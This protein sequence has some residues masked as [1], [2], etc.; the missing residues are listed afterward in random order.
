MSNK[1]SY[2]LFLVLSVFLLTVSLMSKPQRNG[3][4]HEYSLIAKAFINHYSPDILLSDIAERIKDVKINDSENYSI[5]YFENIKKDMQ[6]EKENAGE[7]GIFKTDENKYYGYHFWFYPLLASVSEKVLT[8][9][10]INPLKAFQFINALFFIFALLVLT[11]KEK[12]S[13]LCIFLFFFAG[14]IFYLKWTH[15]EVMLYIFIFFAFFY[16]IKRKEHLSAIFIA[17]ASV[18]VISFSLLFLV[19]PVYHSIVNRK[20]IFMVISG[21]LRQWW[22]WLCGLLSISSVIFYYINYGKLSLIGTEASNIANINAGHFLSYYFDLDQGLWLGAPWVVLYLI[23]YLLRINKITKDVHLDFI[24]S[25]VFSV[26]ICIPLLANNGVNVG[27]SIF[28]RYGLYSIAPLIAWT[29]VYANLILNNNIKKFFILILASG[30]IFSNKGPFA[31]ENYLSHKI[32]T[33]YI[34]EHYPGIY[35]PESYMFILRTFP[36]DQWTDKQASSY[37]YTNNKGIVTKIIYRNDVPS[38]LSNNCSGHYRRISDGHIVD[39]TKTINAGYGWRYLNENM[40]CDG[41]K[42][43]TGMKYLTQGFNSIDFRKKG[44]PDFVMGISGISQEEEWGRWSDG[45]YIKIH[46]KGTF[47]RHTIFDLDLQPFGPNHG[48][49]LV[50]TIDNISRDLILSKDGNYVVEFDFI[51]PVINPYINIE[52]PDPTSPLASGLSNDERKLGIG[53]RKI[54]WQQG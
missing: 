15:P 39:F 32:W 45:K 21:L 2:L 43:Y 12:E 23:F 36:A 14:G 8:G 42:P 50:I 19:I 31:A 7:A 6:N 11:K 53:I 5:D 37:A 27:Q 13:W 4:G 52:I 46:L 44:L 49:K 26:L 28:Q 3:D 10:N 18:Q 1:A 9:L 16:L 40:Y 41:F 47:V 51:T 30:Y 54:S 20:N 34:L 22:V 38:P 48:K 25:L 24:F 17:L 35:N 33:A 29:G